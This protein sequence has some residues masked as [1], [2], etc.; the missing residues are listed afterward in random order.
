MAQYGPNQLQAS[1][2]VSPW[3]IFAAQFKNVLII[4]LLVGTTLSAFLGH[5]TEAAAIGIIVLLATL[6]GFLQEYRA[7]RALEALSHMAAPT[8]TV[9]RDGRESEIPASE[10]VPGDVVLLGTGDRVPADLRLF[11]TINL[12]CDEAALTGESVPVEKQT[13]TL[14]DPNLSVGD[15]SNMG[16]VGTIVTYGRGLGMVV[17]TGK[18]TEFGKVARM[19]QTVEVSRTPLQENLN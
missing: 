4:I 18:Q 17:V 13:F 8:A 3:T 15:R 1:D 10:L 6:L 12:Q 5:T 9:F 16:Y 19:L 2:P 11:K 14:D 7:E